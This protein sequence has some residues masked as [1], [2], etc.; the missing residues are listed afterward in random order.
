MQHGISQK[1]SQRASLGQ[2]RMVFKCD[3]QAV[4]FPETAGFEIDIKLD[5]PKV[6]PRLSWGQPD[7]SKATLAAI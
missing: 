7:G 5:R 6:K 1:G 4:N 3:N 2:F